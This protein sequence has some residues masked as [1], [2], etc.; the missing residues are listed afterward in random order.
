MSGNIEVMRVL[1][2]AGVPADDGSLQDAVENCCVEP[3]TLLLNAG[4]DPNYPSTLP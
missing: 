2:A 4:R 3:A 1:I